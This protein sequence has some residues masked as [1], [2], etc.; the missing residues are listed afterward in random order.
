MAQLC[1][2][3]PQMSTLQADRSFSGVLA[4]FEPVDPLGAKNENNLVN[5]Q[6]FC[7]LSDRIGVNYFY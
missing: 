1:C 5:G 4:R 7:F 2:S 6:F 3:I